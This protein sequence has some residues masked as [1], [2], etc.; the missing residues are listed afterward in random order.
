MR[1]EWDP[2][3]IHK[4]W[5]PLPEY[6]DMHIDSWGKQQ[7]DSLHSQMNDIQSSLSYS[8]HRSQGYTPEF[9]WITKQ[10]KLQSTDI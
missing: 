1:Q 5:Q 4:V 8:G 9:G 7:I 10:S 2:A 3:F 6:I